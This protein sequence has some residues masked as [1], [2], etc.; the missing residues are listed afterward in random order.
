MKLRLI[1]SIFLALTI[2]QVF[3]FDIGLTSTEKEVP[4]NEWG[5]V[6]DDMQISI[7]LNASA[8]NIKTNQSVKFSFA[9][10]I[11]QPMRN[12]VYTCK[13]HFSPPQVCRLP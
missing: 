3:G 7:G 10:K 13:E 9:L 1:F 6:T 8:N 12:T 11:F 4:A 2:W 5:A